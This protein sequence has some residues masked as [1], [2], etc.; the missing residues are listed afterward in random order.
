M[1]VEPFRTCNLLGPIIKPWPEGRSTGPSHRLPPCLHP[2]CRLQVARTGGCPGDRPRG[3]PGRTAAVPG[4]AAAGPRA[5]GSA[6]AGRFPR[7]GF[8][9]LQV[10]SAPGL[11]RWLRVPTRHTLSTRKTPPGIPTWPS[12]ARD[13]HL[14]LQDQGA[15]VPGL[16]SSFLLRNAVI[17]FGLRRRPGVSPPFCPLLPS[18]SVPRARG[19]TRYTL[20]VCVT[21]LECVTVYETAFAPSVGVSGVPGSRRAPRS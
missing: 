20:L 2:L 12:P 18:A 1:P 11:P 19:S 3:S 15:P 6:G 10:G 13:R 17:S 5:E 9:C 21:G 14:S 8:C 4:G 16:A 7:T